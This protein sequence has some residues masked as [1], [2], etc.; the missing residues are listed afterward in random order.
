MLF[1]SYTFIVFFCAV[2]ILHRL[3]FSWQVKKLNLVIASYLFYMAW[4][5]PYVVLL[6]I[7]TVTDW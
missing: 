6:W 2:L 5:P 1:N 4:N 3:P 7:S